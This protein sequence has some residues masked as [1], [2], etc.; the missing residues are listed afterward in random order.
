MF[1]VLFEVRPKTDQWDAYLGNAKMLRPELEEIDGFVDNIRYKSLTR[2]GWILSLSGWRDEKALVRWRTRAKHHEVQERGR[3]EIL[4]D[5]HLRVGQV[6]RDT[7]PP[8]G[9][10]LREQ[11]LDETETGEGTTVTLIDARRPAEWVKGS[12]PEDVAWWL[13]LAPE[14][15]GLVTW[16]VFDAVLTPGAVILL[17]SWHGQTAAEAFEGTVSLPD[18]ARLRR[19]RVVRDYGMFDR[20]EAPQYYPEVTRPS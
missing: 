3:S 5:Y 15:P 11:R 13:G 16:D 2:E 8:A 4:S 14:A 1:S 17:A 12:T 9:H 18:G 10:I 7:A 19:I 6:T 20:R